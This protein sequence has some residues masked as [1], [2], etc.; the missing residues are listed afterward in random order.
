MART[1][2]HILY[3][4]THEFNELI[5]FFIEILL[6]HDIISRDFIYTLDIIHHMNI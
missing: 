3:Q 4:Y 2:T 5:F 6:L 1:H